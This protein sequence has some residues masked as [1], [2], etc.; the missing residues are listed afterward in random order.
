MTPTVFKAEVSSELIST[1]K[2]HHKS[3]AGSEQTAFFLR[4]A[5]ECARD[6]FDSRKERF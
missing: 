1:R 2:I 6:R 5:D 3:H 4:E